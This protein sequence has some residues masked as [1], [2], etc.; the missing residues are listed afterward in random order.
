AGFNPAF[1][2]YS[3]GQRR[4]QQ[5]Q[6]LFDDELNV[7]RRAVAETAAA[8]SENAFD[9]HLGALRRV[10]DIVE[11]AAQRAAFRGLLVRQ[12][13]VP[14]DCSEYVI[15]VMGN[16]A[17]ERADSLHLL[18]LSQLRFQ[19]FFLGLREL[20]RIHIAGRA[21]DPHRLA[22]RVAQA[23][24]TRMQ[25]MPIAVGLTDAI[26]AVIPRGTTLEVVFE[27]RFEARP[28][29]GMN[30]DLR[31]PG[32]ARTDL[33]FGTE[34]IE[35]FHRLRHKQPVGPDVPVPVPFVGSFHGE[36]VALLAL[37]Q[38]SLTRGDAPY[39]T[40]QSVDGEPAKQREDQRANADTDRL[41][42]PRP[43]CNGLFTRHGNRDGSISYVRNRDEIALSVDR[44]EE[45]WRGRRRRGHERRELLPDFSRCR[46]TAG[47]QCPVVAH[48]LNRAAHP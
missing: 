41:I 39:L 22:R 26:F 34:A 30:E 16:A 17:G 27:G 25:P 42:A 8:E 9:Q 14:Q 33:R 44:A 45:P 3:R 1:Q 28:V 20:L 7:H 21:Y 24:A 43:Q 40:Q 37:T 10:H 32:A 15:E 19:L 12:F 4:F 35:H 36:C 2:A 11:V 6:R 29:V 23:A 46:W 18:R 5:L 47:E 13:A 38:R 31:Q 48:H